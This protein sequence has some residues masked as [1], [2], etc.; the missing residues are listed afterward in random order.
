MAAVPDVTPTSSPT[1]VLR[2]LYLGRFVFALLWAAL[3]GAVAG[4]LG[5]PARLLLVLYPVVDLA[6]ALVDV[7]SRGTDGRSP[8]V[9]YAN[10]A[11]SAVA[12]VALA[13]VGGEPTG[14]LATWG[15]WAVAAGATQLAVGVARRAV[16]GQWPIMLSGG[17]S[18]LAGIAFLAMSSGGSS[19]TGIAGY[20]TLGGIFFL[21]SALR[22]GRGSAD[23]TAADR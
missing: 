13:V 23:R 1:T 21:A 20:A 9:L 18:V 19:V 3:F 12:A 16:G 5:A 2:R 17:L 6:A 15:L 11:F 7:R 10:V 14:V 8:A 4:D 22:L